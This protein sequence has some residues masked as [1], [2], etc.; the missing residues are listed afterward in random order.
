MSMFFLPV[1]ES[2]NEEGATEA[3]KEQHE[4]GL[5]SHGWR[6]RA[7]DACW[8]RSK[9]IVAWGISPFAWYSQDLLAILPLLYFTF[10]FLSLIFMISFIFSGSGFIEKS[11]LT[12]GRSSATEDWGAGKNWSS[13]GRIG[14]G[15]SPCAPEGSHITF[16]HILYP[17]PTQKTL[18][19]PIHHHLETTPSGAWRSCT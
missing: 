12:E 3:T 5:S 16:L 13:S 18:P 7:S 2:S 14:D 6:W 19:H 15:R 9:E 17:T 4:L 11:Q 1:D 8:R 10:L